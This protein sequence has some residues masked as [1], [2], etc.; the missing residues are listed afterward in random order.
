MS[1][2]QDIPPQLRSGWIMNCYDWVGWGMDERMM[3]LYQK[4][5]WKY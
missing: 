4:G 3:M 2:G 1:E 5:H